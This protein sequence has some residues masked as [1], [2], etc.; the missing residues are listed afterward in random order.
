MKEA[1]ITGLD[2]LYTDVVLVSN[3]ESG[4]TPLYEQHAPDLDA[5]PSAEASEPVLTGYRVIIPVPPGLYH[6]RFGLSTW[7]AYAE[8]ECQAYEAYL[9]GPLAEWQQS[10]DNEERGEMPVYT[11][12]KQ[13]EFWTE[14]LTPEEIS[15]LHPPVEPTDNDKIQLALAEMALAQA[16]HMDSLQ[17]AL[18]EIAALLP[19]G[20]V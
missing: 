17:L 5:E 11:P 20:D 4:V 16:E 7:N 9:Q 14:G 2:G 18:A 3:A 1:I 8:V 13:P 19:G 6:P 12:A 10:T 15:A